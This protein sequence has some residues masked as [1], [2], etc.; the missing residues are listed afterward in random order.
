VQE[1]LV[2]TYLS[3]EQLHVE[4][5]I[6]AD[7]TASCDF[8]N[9]LSGSHRVYYRGELSGHHHELRPCLQFCHFLRCFLQ[10][11]R[12]TGADKAKAETDLQVCLLFA[13]KKLAFKKNPS[14]SLWQATLPKTT[15]SKNH[16]VLRP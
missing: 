6:S 5:R 9:Q 8:W 3:D 11:A 7:F 2:R 1:P 4:L 14:R 16:V 12:T 15:A 13:A 10:A